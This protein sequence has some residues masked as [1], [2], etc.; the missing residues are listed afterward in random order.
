MK[1]INDGSWEGKKVLLRLDLDVPIKDGKVLDNTRLLAARDSVEFLASKVSNLV[2]C[3]KIGRPEGYDEGLSTKIILSE[4][5]TIF[6]FEIGYINNYWVENFNT[7]F[8]LLENLRFWKEDEENDLEFARKMAS[9]FDCF[10]N[11]SFATAHRVAASSV[12]ITELLD[13]YA[14][15]RM[16]AEVEHLSRLVKYPNRPLVSIIGGAKIETKLPVINALSKISDKVLVGGLLPKE[17]SEK[18][19]SFDLNVI[20][21][22]LVESGKD[23]SMKSVEDF[24]KIINT[25]KEI[26]WNG[27]IGN[28]EQELY[29][30]GTKTL[31]EI[32]MRSNAKITV[33]GGDTISALNQFGDISKVDWVSLGGGAMLDFIAGVKMPG[34]EALETPTIES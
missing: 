26:V 11:D 9:G 24:E 5:E 7:K 2:I 8:L 22:E 27:P 13:S 23:V 17:I 28:F 32:L 10:V 4:L 20:V 1:R 29:S 3:G 19:I 12:A 14:G 25:A 34:I 30:V 6:G 31:V 21:A 16:V 33:G 18:N 15:M